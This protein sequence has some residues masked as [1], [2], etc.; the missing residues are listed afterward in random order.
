MIGLDKVILNMYREIL[1]H[2]GSFGDSIDFEAG[3]PFELILSPLLSNFQKTGISIAILVWLATSID[4]STYENAVKNE[5]RRLNEIEERIYP[6][7][8]AEAVEAFFQSEEGYNRALKKVYSE[9]IIPA[10][11]AHESR[12]I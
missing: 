5:H 11:K 10:L 1:F 8:V 7:L 6:N 2:E 4:N 12:K 9:I 3:N